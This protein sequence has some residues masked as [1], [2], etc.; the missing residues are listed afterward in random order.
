[1]K[2][3]IFISILFLFAV[4]LKAQSSIDWKFEKTVNGVSV[5]RGYKCY[6]NCSYQL[7]LVKLKNETS[8]NKKI[9][10]GDIYFKS[11]STDLGKVNGA[12]YTLKAYETIAG[13][14]Y[15]LLWNVPRGWEN[16]ATGFFS[17]ITV[18]NIQ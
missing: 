18:E 16:K 1:M 13:E 2:R 5:Y 8:Y 10:I 7:F 9:N 14:K 15:G 6:D 17:T 12:T 11:Y 3:S 4:T